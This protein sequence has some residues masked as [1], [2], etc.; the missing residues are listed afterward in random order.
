MGCDITRILKHFDSPQSDLK[1]TFYDFS[2]FGLPNE[3]LVNV[4]GRSCNTYL[5]I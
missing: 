2:V 4:D 3:P 5:G 1:M